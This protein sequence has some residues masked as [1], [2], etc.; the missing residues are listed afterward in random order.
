MFCAPVNHREYID[1][2]VPAPQAMGT[3]F[4][5]ANRGNPKTGRAVHQTMNLRLLTKLKAEKS[6]TELCFCVWTLDFGLQLSHQAQV[7]CLV[8]STP[9]LWVSAVSGPEFGT[10]RLRRWHFKT[11]VFVVIDGSAKHWTNLW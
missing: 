11:G 3:K 2:E 7:H 5:S 6:G 9:R 10:Q 1:L 4:R 8:N